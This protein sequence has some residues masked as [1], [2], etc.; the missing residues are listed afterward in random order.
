[1]RIYC[2]VRLYNWIILPLVVHKVFDPIKIARF[3]QS[4]TIDDRFRIFSVDV[5]IRLIFMFTAY[6][7]I[8]PTWEFQ[9]GIIFK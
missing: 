1:M 4:F 2:T 7:S 6:I 3:Y 9:A 5:D 8:N